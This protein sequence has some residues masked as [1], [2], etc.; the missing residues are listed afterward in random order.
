[1]WN[2]KL[3]LLIHYFTLLLISGAG[4]FVTTIVVGA[5]TITNPFTLTQRPFLRDI[6]FYMFAAYW[7]FYLLWT[8]SVSIYHAVGF[9]VFYMFYVVVVI[10]GRII[11]QKWKKMRQSK[12]LGTGDI[13]SKSLSFNVLIGKLDS[14]MVYVYVHTHTHTHT[15]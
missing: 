10:L 4:I 15:P 9:V 6:I 5:V 2:E 11:F 3:K 7:T 1:M 14:Y 8:G 12:R 13:P